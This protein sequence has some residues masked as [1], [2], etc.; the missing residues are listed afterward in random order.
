MNTYTILGVEIE[1]QSEHANGPTVLLKQEWGGTVHQVEVHELHLRWLAQRLGDS[2]MAGMQRALLRCWDM[3]TAL[4]RDLKLTAD[5]GREDLDLE[6]ARTGELVDFLAF[7]C[8]DFREPDE[9]ADGRKAP[10]AGNPG[11][12]E[13]VGGLFAQ[14]A[15]Q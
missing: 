1:V 5:F 3:A 11:P 13:P 12:T 10:P 14:G 6:L 7:I 2:S 4:Q 15:K 8:A 9:P